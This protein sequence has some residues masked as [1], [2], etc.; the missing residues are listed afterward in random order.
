MTERGNT[1]CPIGLRGAPKISV[2]RCSEGTVRVS[3][4]EF[5]ISVRFVL[6]IALSKQQWYRWKNNRSFEAGDSK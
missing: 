3:V 5:R 1:I 4:H 2:L 6:Y